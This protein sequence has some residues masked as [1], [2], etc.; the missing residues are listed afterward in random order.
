MTASGK[1][2]DA[3]KCKGDYFARLRTRPGET[4]SRSKLGVDLVKLNDFYKDQG[5]AYVNVNPLTDVDPEKRKV[6]VT[7]EIERGAL[8]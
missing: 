2:C 1:D 5:Y 6:N 8:V 7:F 3:A 4:F